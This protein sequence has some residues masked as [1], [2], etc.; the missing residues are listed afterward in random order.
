MDVKFAR[1]PLCYATHALK[2]IYDAYFVVIKWVIYI[3]HKYSTLLPIVTSGRGIPLTL[4][5]P[6]IDNNNYQILAIY[7]TNYYGDNAF[8]TRPF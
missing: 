4:C 2:V 7:Q 3:L 5:Q 6:N 1:L 8:I